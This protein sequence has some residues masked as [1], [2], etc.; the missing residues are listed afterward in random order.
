[1]DY[2]RKK[3]LLKGGTAEDQYY[4][5]KSKNKLNSCYGC[6]VT[7][8]CQSSVEYE[9]GEY[10]EIQE[11]KQKLLDKYYRSRNSFLSYQHGVWVTAHS[12]MRL[13]RAMWDIVGSDMVYCDTDSIYFATGYDKSKLLQHNEKLKAI[14]KAG[15]QANFEKLGC[16]EFEGRYKRFKTLGSKRYIKE[17]YRKDMP[18]HKYKILYIKKSNKSRLH[19]TYYLTLNKTSQTIAGLGK[20]AMIEYA[21]KTHQDIFDIFRPNATILNTFTSKLTTHYEDTPHSDIIN[22]ELMQE[23]SSVSLMPSDF[24]MY[25]PPEYLQLILLTRGER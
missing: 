22:G 17:Y 3:T 13:R 2:F 23:L 12:R 24:K 6:M 21:H 11:D 18:K 8:I 5:M 20:T 14:N 10:I 15:K 19:R 16:Y 4:Y 9:N 25:L 7:D 1:M